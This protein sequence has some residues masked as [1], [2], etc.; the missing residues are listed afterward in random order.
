MRAFVAIT[1]WLTLAALSSSCARAD[2]GAPSNDRPAAPEFTHRLP[3]DWINATPQS[4]AALRGKVVLIDFWAFECWN[5]YR[6]FPWL[7]AVHDRFSG[8]PFQVIGVHTP[9]Y[10]SEHDRRLLEA[11]MRQFGLE[12][13]VMIDNDYSYWRAMQNQ[14]WPAFYLVD[15]T[16]RLRY[17]YA[18]ETHPGDPTAREI[19]RRIAELIAE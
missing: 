5:C 2:T 14:Y 10:P 6:S 19:E 9:E 17:G 1:A 8:Q 11:R 4:L 7:N 3:E 16:G 18:G 13:P 12:H 15:K